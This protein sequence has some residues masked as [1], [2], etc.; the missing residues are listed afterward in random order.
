MKRKIIE[1]NVGHL[2]HRLGYIPGQVP[3][4]ISLGDGLPQ[5]EFSLAEVVLAILNYLGMEI[6]FQKEK[7][8]ILVKK[9]K[10]QKHSKKQD[11]CGSY[12]IRG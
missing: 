7:R 11:V 3:I 8:V 1:Q 4:W 12:I 2:N 10:G 9:R 5:A 6:E